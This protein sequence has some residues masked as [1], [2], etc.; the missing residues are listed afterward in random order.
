MP[1][2]RGHVTCNQDKPEPDP[3]TV[4]DADTEGEEKSS[5]RRDPTQMSMIMRRV[6]QAQPRRHGWILMLSKEYIQTFKDMTT[7]KKR[8][9]KAKVWSSAWRHCKHVVPNMKPCHLQSQSHLSHM[10][11][12]A[13]DMVVSINEERREEILKKRRPKSTR[14]DQIVNSYVD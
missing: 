8:K 2:S 1:P 3:Y 12:D 9:K 11:R 6:S 14:F 4:D 13:Y 7:G 10:H 5:R